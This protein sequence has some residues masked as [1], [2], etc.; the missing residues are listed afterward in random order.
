M[1]S[2]RL[3]RFTRNILRHQSGI[4]FAKDSCFGELSQCVRD[5]IGELFSLDCVPRNS[6]AC[7]IK[8]WIVVTGQDRNVLRDSLS[9]SHEMGYDRHNMGRPGDK[10][11]CRSIGDAQSFVQQGT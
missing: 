5:A 4:G 2:E 9:A 7:R 10:V 6:R 8:N 11:R 1:S 3:E